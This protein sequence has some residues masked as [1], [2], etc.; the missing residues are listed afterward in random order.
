MARTGRYDMLRPRRCRY[1]PCPNRS[2]LPR[3]QPNRQHTRKQVTLTPNG[4][5]TPSVSR[6]SPRRQ[7]YRSPWR[8]GG[9]AVALGQA[10]GQ[11]VGEA[12]AE[13]A[14][15]VQA[16]VPRPVQRIAAPAHNVVERDRADLVAEPVPAG[17]DPANVKRVPEARCPEP[18]YYLLPA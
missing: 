14:R 11:D 4:A 2:R 17:P 10:H 7:S 8:C 9:V 12:G 3:S 15:H 16:V 5:L 6:P 13:V 18:A 1:C